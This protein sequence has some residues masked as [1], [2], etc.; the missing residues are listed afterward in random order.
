LPPPLPRDVFL[1]RQERVRE[2]MRKADLGALIVVP[3]TNLAYAANLDV[4]RSERLIALVLRADK[5]AVL[6]SPSFEE[7]RVRR[8]AVVT[9][10]LTWR[11]EEDPIALLK[12]ALAG[13][14]RAGFEGS[15]DWHTVTL[16]RQAKGPLST[17]ATALFDALRE[18][19]REEELVLLRDAAARTERAIAATHR[20]LED[21]LSERRIAEILEDEF[22]KERVRGGGLVQIGPSSALPH[23]GP[24]DQ[25]LK[26]GSVLLIDCG[27][28]VRG[29]SSDIT[30]TVSWGPPSDEVRRVYATVA[31]AQAA[32][33][34]VFR[35]GARPEDV[36]RAARKVIEDAGHGAYFTHRLGHGLGMDGHETPYLV[37]GNKTPLVAG[38]VCTIE[39]GIYQPGR[40]GVRI[41]D[42]FRVTAGEAEAF[43]NPPAEL[44]VLAG[45]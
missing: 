27:C 26:K 6:I 18:V 41:E 30:R 21:G 25:V 4:H 31:K 29:Y 5:G 8:D 3:S 23:G 17:D 33:R 32:G 12:K 7:E 1:A 10:V 19:K 37:K 44:A 16:L 22:R 13:V 20:R 35:A 38:N 28:R 2:G 39:P 36:D 42:D 43:L 40:F 11:E 45:V 15:T 9:D 14:T 24:S 34:A